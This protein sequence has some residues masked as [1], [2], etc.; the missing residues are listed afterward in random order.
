MSN[1]HYTRS[2]IAHAALKFLPPLI[3]MSLLDET[4]FRQEYGLRKEAV[5]N[6]V[7]SGVSIQRSRLFDVVRQSLSGAAEMVVTDVDDREWK[8]RNEAETGQ[9]PKLEIFSEE[10]RLTL[11]GFEVLSPVATVRLSY[12]DESA[13]DVNLPTSAQVSW[14]EILA[15]R[16][17]EDD[18]VDLFLSDLGDT[19]VHLIRTIRSEF[20]SGKSR[21]SSLVP[22]SRR[23]FERL[24][25]SY[26][27]S[28]SIREYAGGAG[29]RLIKELFAWRPY[30][31][32][33]FS[34]L[35]SSHSAL[36]AE[37]CIEHLE[38]GDLVRAYDFI[39]RCGDM[40][41]RLGATEVGLRIL[42]GNPEIEPYL[43]RLIK[44]IRDDDVDGATSG[45]KLFSALF[46]LVDGEL[47]R[48]RLMCAAP[49][50]YRRLASLSHAA[51]IH[52]QLV[53]LDIEYEAFCEWAFNNRG[54]QYFMQSLTD[55][56][57]EP[58][59]NPESCSSSAN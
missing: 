43:L 14:R 1:S 11:P 59:W 30:E 3:R 15:E 26:D 24:V 25:G 37:I 23:Y 35:V 2:E 28:A 55:M 57:I 6:F 41:S 5:L 51:L 52:R 34:L 53:N 39:E 19:P 33:L 38:S 12:L 32:F 16:A 49:L 7:E 45:F 44:R 27:G 13:V 58:R 40:T 20:L 21:V 8:L 18:E 46:V 48:T 47:A 31:G 17:L 54:E 4:E 9:P 22:Y 42:P 10:R 50:F 36:T 56:R 29:G